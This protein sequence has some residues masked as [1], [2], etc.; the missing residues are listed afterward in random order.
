MKAK[1][2]FLDKVVV[3]TGAA[4]GIGFGLSEAMA[5]LGA[6]VV[7]TDHNQANLA[8]HTER[9]KNEGLDIFSH[10]LDVRDAEAFKQVIAFC[11]QE[12][13]PV[14]V[15]VN[16]A[17]I[18]SVGFV[19]DQ[20]V[21]DWQPIIDVN[22]KGVIHG[23]HA[24]YPKMIERASGNIINIASLAGLVP[25]PASASY[26]M[27]K[28]AVVGLSASLRAEA[29]AFGVNVSVI[30]PSFVSTNIFEASKRFKIS[31]S[32]T[33]RM[34]RSAGGMISLESFVAEA[35]EEIPRQ[36]A[37]IVIPRKA[38][39]IYALS[40]WLPGYLQKSQEAMAG[41]LAQRLQE[42]DKSSKV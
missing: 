22:I 1:D 27:S 5:R 32:M 20:Q 8:K 2:Y 4:S 12:V 19:S 6:R 21:E 41:R 24:V 9:L 40:R 26:A 33:E 30:C 34:V 42:A 38:R 29:K 37:R 11:E 18:A 3:V 25:V 7:L 23:I 28:H 31:S 17:G 13:G 16:N 14:D 35:I 10:L 36:N 15:L 39:L